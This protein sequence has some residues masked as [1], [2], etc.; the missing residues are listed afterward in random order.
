MNLGGPR[1]SHAGLGGQAIN[2]Q[3]SSGIRGIG[4]I[5]CANEHSAI[6]DSRHYELS[7]VS[8]T[9]PSTALLTVPQLGKNGGR[10][11]MLGIECV[12]QRRR[13]N[14]AWVSTRPTISLDYPHD[15]STRFDAIR[16][17]HRI[18]SIKE[19]RLRTGRRGLADRRRAT[20]RAI[21]VVL[22]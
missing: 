11:N 22:M 5:H 8:S 12:K 6:C 10:V 9:I 16:R 17:D 15:T 4:R 14:Y 18:R 7:R 21:D 2:I 1:R 13:R 19:M 20:G 3:P